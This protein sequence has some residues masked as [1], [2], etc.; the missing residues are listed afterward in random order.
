M[1]IS[2]WM[3]L[4]TKI[5]QAGH[6]FITWKLQLKSINFFKSKESNEMNHSIIEISKTVNKNSIKFPFFVTYWH[7][8][9]F[10]TPTVAVYCQ[11]ETFHQSGIKFLV[12]ILM[13]C[14]LGILF[15]DLETEITNQ[16]VFQPNLKQS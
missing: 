8:K 9:F 15:H 1:D 4:K 12:R 14:R 16:S 5:W 7:E 11:F 2:C 6:G 10:E 13:D 3:Q